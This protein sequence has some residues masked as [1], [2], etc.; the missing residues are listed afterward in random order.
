MNELILSINP[1]SHGLNQ[2]D[3]DVVLISNGRI[4]FGVEEERIN[5]IK[6]SEGI[7]PVESIRKA[8][9]YCNKTENDITGI[10]ICY[11]PRLFLDRIK[12]ELL[13]IIKK[14]IKLND[15][16]DIMYNEM[17]SS[18]IFSRNEFFK[19]DERVKDYIIQKCSFSN[20][21]INISFIDH[22]LSHIASSY[23]VSGF[24]SA[25][26]VVADGIG[27]SATTT[28]WKI[29]NNKYEIIKKINYPNSL[30]YFYAIAT[31]YLGFEPWRHEGKTMALAAYGHK[32]DDIY[33]RLITIF[34]I[35]DDFYDCSQFIFRNSGLYLMVDMN[36][37]LKELEN[38]FGV[39]PRDNNTPITQFYIDFAWAVQNLLENSIIKLINYA[40][41]KT[42]ISNVCAAGGLFMNCKMN[43]QVREHSLAKE[44]FV[45]PLAGDMGLAIGAGLL[46]SN[47]KYKDSFKSLYFGPD[48]SNEYIEKILKKSGLHY[49][50]PNNLFKTVAREI[51]Y[52]KIV[53][54]FQ[55]RMEMGARA[56][57]NRSI[58][59]DP[60]DPHMSDK[61]NELI[62]H[63]EKW[64]PFAC[65]ILA[66]K[67]GEVLE[68]YSIN[69]CSN[70]MIEAYR[71]KDDWV[72]KIPS[73]I[74]KS[75]NTTRPQ[76]V[77]YE[78]NPYFYNLISEFYNI[79]GCPLVLN[80]SLN[81][82]GQ[83]I[84]MSPEMVVEFFK[85]CS[86]E[87]LVIG[88]FVVRINDQKENIHDI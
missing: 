52:G 68:N 58:L 60:R 55:G 33:D 21:D 54:W 26:G 59:A 73:V 80:T 20:R 23:E 69:N 15:Y 47:T 17:V 4:L 9:D 16:I 34:D 86:A 42:H 44:Y 41:K 67:C 88:D 27:E 84:I 53:L 78:Y 63:R 19:N 62:K 81:D 77:E 75:D 64:R 43:M 56:L 2:H 45:Q 24:D 25:V 50:R 8:L 7:F 3:P 85:K 35:T 38:L 22:H 46:L 32:D 57:G 40:V 10:S 79:T 51:S 70:F 12:L 48:Y 31:K 66:E 74:H 6:G 5:G 83:P 13:S 29:V 82:K 37:A 30:G 87:I 1:C 71:V 14:N 65:S 49:Y 11:D 36:K 18:D 61:I 39:K 76:S 72:K 28:I